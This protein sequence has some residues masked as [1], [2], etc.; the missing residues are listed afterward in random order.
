[1]SALIDH[2]SSANRAIESSLN[3]MYFKRLVPGLWVGT[4]V[5]SSSSSVTYSH[6]HEYHRV[7]RKTYKYVGMTKTGADECAEA[8]K[9]IYTRT[10]KYQR[11][12]ST[13]GYMG[14]WETIVST[15]SEISSEIVIRHVGGDMWEV[16]I[17]VNEDSIF[18]S[19]TDTPQTYSVIFASERQRSYD[20]ETET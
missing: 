3:V 9:S 15:G 8:M 10:V 11:W 19:K 16:D 20:G 12:N 1:V 17:S 2:Y 14:D 5:V 13:A 6:M 7:A 18:M 4:S